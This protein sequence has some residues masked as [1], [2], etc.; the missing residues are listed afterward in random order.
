MNLNSIP[1][2]TSLIYTLAISVHAA[3][4][5][6]VNLTVLET[7]NTTQSSSSGKINVH[8]DVLLI[9]DI[10]AFEEDD[11]NR[12]FMDKKVPD[13]LIAIKDAVTKDRPIIL[14]EMTNGFTNKVIPTHPK[15][16]EF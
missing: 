16:M 2:I 13:Y 7:E 12:A 3:E 8:Y 6:N 4:L 14:I 10:W 5:T 9:V 1:I 15:I 11:T